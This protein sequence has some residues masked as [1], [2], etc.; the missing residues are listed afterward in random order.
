MSR[1]AT[2][3]SSRSDTTASPPGS[4][5]PSTWPVCVLSVLLLERIREDRVET[6]DGHLSSALGAHPGFLGPGDEVCVLKK[7]VFQDLLL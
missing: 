5:A 6:E 4:G 3:D 2:G 1:K 7:S